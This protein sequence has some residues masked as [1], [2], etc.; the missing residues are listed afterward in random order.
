[1][2]WQSITNIAY[3]SLEER[4]NVIISCEAITSRYRYE[5]KR[6]P[7]IYYVRLLENI[8]IS[9]CPPGWVEGE[10]RRIL[11]LMENLTRLGSRSAFLLHCFR[12]RLQGFLNSLQSLLCLNLEVG[13]R[14]LYQFRPE[15]KP[16]RV[17][18]ES[19]LDPVKHHDVERGLNWKYEFSINASLQRMRRIKV[20]A[21]NSY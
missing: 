21:K 10:L 11:L 7:P 20:V 18:R 3:I 14:Y 19:M 1:M 9:I 12:F 6:M 4:N 2:G 8:S 15:T 17:S 13:S 16:D 5:G